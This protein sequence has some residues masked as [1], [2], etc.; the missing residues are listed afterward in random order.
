[1][2]QEIKII[3]EKGKVLISERTIRARS[4]SKTGYVY[5]KMIVFEKLY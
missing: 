1:M 4:S 3:M 2:I 5:L